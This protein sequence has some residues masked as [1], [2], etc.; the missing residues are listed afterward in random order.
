MLFG[1]VKQIAL[2]ADALAG[3]ALGLAA[4]VLLGYRMGW[5]CRPTRATGL[6]PG[7]A[8][9]PGGLA[10][11][12]WPGLLAVAAVTVAVGMILPLLDL[13]WPRS[14]SST[15]PSRRVG[16]GPRLDRTCRHRGD[17]PARPP[18]YISAVKIRRHAS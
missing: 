2:A 18:A 14:S 6:R 7:A 3:L 13:S 16:S 9:P 5:Q 15:C 17:A 12:P 1:Q 4:L 8:I 10:T 11:L